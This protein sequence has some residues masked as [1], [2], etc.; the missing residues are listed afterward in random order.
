MLKKL[1]TKNI[2]IGAFFIF[3]L[4]Y[5][6]LRAWFVAPIHDE[7]AT[8]FHYIETGKI[9][10]DEAL[11]DA[12]NHILNSW[13]GY[14]F[15]RNFG[16]HFFLFRLPSLI[17]FVAYF[18]ATKAIIEKFNIGK[19]KYL[20]F[21]ALNTIPWITDY[22][23]YTR[24][25]GLAIGLFMSALYYLLS[26]IDDKKVSQL[27]IGLVLLN[28][29]VFANLTYM[30]ISLLISCYWFL[31]IIF[32]WTSWTMKQRVFLSASYLLF[33]LLLI[34]LIQ[35]SFDLKEAGALYYG[36]LNGLWEVTG[37]TV[38]KYVLFYS[39]NWL[40]IAF[41]VLGVIGVLL[42]LR[43]IWRQSFKLVLAKNTVIFLYLII[44]NILG[45]VFLAKVMHIN[46]PEDRAAMYFVPLLL[47]LIVQLLGENK[48]LKYGLIGLLFFP[49]SFLLQLNVSTSIF[50]PDDR[51]SKAFYDQVRTE[52]QTDETIGIDP[53]MQLTYA[54]HERHHLGEIQ[55]GQT[56]GAFSP[57]FDVIL[58]KSTI[59]HTPKIAQ[60]YT[61]F[62]TD[63]AS[64]YQAFKRK[65]N[66]DS[67]LLVDTLVVGNKSTA[68]FID[69]FHCSIDKTWKNKLIKVVIDSEMDAQNPL[70]TVNLVITTEDE[71]LQPVRYDYQNIRWYFA[72]T[73]KTKAFQQ[74]YSF[75]Q[76]GKNEKLLKIYIWNPQKAAIRLK[77]SRI[78]F[79]ELN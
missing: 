27:A 52:I 26:F 16:E 59:A 14:F 4:T 9:W 31:F 19:W 65:K 64:T 53:I 51:M 75:K 67:K 72:Q 21:V 61:L 66:F 8:F 13:I 39:E 18:F 56:I 41:I 50:S 77:N 12:N 48:M 25:Y 5:F 40:K 42:V 36:S 28:L 23:S 11:K 44:G 3:L 30:I 33:G 73:N 1:S 78:K 32:H 38:T 49:V 37:K 6:L 46:Y 47:I 35:F 15:Y 54:L 10:G 76:I 68:E 79:F 55:L 60:D 45:I 58:T 62:A 34:P 17:A 24:G 2:L 20:G 70:N 22:F 63:K 57:Y 71:N 43:S 7:V 29:T 74:T 69:C